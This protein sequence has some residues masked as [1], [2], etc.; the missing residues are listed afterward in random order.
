MNEKTE[1]WLLY[2]EDDA[3]IARAMV[4]LFVRWGC[5]VVH[6]TSLADALGELER[7]PF[8]A[9]VTDWDLGGGDTGE[10]VVKAARGL[11]LPVRVFSGSEPMPGFEDIWLAKMNPRALET[12]L[13]EIR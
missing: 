1:L 7:G 11:V 6:A 2:V 5:V 10:L 9:V 3:V 13:K 12:W 4:R 8:S